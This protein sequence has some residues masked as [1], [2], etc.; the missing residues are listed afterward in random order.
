M[1]DSVL[2]VVS[3]GTDNPNRSTRAIHHPALVRKQGQKV[4]LFPVDESIC[5]VTESRDAKFRDTDGDTTSDLLIH[6][7][8]F[9]IPIVDDPPTRQGRRATASD[10]FR[11]NRAGTA[12]GISGPGCLSRVAFL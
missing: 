12:A 8:E 1:N 4:S 6:L 3:C 7:Q 5:P 10:S 11:G 9:H 2:V